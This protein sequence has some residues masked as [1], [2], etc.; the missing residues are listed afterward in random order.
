MKDIFK[1]AE[2]ISK[3]K[4]GELIDEERMLLNDWKA[5]GEVEQAAYFYSSDSNRIQKKHDLYK[6]LDKDKAWKRILEQAPDIVRPIVN[7][8]N[9]LKWAALF[10]LPLLAST[11]LLNEVYRNE[12]Q[13]LVEVG[14]SKATLQ[15]SN[16]K[17]ICLEDFQGRDI[18]VGKTKLASNKY[19][20]LIY[21]Q[22]EA[23][24]E[25]LVYNTITTPVQGEYSMVLSDGSKVYLNAQTS[26]VFPVEFGSGKREL[27]LKEGEACFEVSKDAKRPFI[28]HL[29]NGSEVEVLGT[30][31]NVMAYA[32][33]EEI[34]TTLLEGKVQFAYGEAKV[35]LGP[36]EQSGLNRENNKISVRDVKASEFFAWREGRFVFNR[37]PLGSVFRKMSRWYGV[38]INCEDRNLLN[39]RIS[40]VINRYEDIDKLIRLIEEVSPVK[41]DLDEKKIIVSRK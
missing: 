40:G 33:E 34:Q 37:E 15:L 41:I 23:V 28:V 36:G 25:D 6:S 38:E 21:Q 2:L 29:S 16:G 30:V 18:K 1:I 26:L 19:N 3:E 10:L 31:F 20:N 24:E 4:V 32:D 35:L 22:G 11:Y 39:R 17:I 12:N 13:V 14:S 9:V 7:L 5:N 8:R 27:I